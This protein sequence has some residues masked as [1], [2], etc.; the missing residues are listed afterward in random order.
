MANESSKPFSFPVQ[1]E[2]F[3]TSSY[4]Q[5]NGIITRCVRV[6]TTKDG[7]AVRDSKDT[8]RNKTTLYF[9]PDEWAAFI[10]GAKNG[11]FDPRL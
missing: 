6:A 10:K 5:P 3:E 2:Q 4:S 7:V 8:K 11:E 1:D 9:S